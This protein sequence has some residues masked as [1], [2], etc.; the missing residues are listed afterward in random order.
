MP[1]VKI[2]MYKDKIKL[3]LDGEEVPLRR[4]PDLVPLYIDRVNPDSSGAVVLEG[5]AWYGMEDELLD[6][7]QSEV[8]E[9]EPSNTTPHVVV[10]SD[11]GNLVITDHGTV[12]EV[13]ARYGKDKYSTRIRKTPSAL[14]A[15]TP[16]LLSLRMLG[17]LD[18]RFIEFL[19]KEMR[20]RS[21]VEYLQR[22]RKEFS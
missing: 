8:Y 1:K 20:S 22:L 17:R 9:A 19:V 18:R 14:S 6:I 4:L 7:V 5:E 3:I 13:N 15:L 16:Q 12:I 21:V 2:V 11:S 10:K